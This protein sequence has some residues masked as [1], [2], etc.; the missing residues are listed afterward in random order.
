MFFLRFLFLQAFLQKLVRNLFAEGNDLFREK[1]FKLALVQ[2]VEGLNVA[3]YAASDEVAIPVDLL[4]KLHV[5]RA[6]CYF[7][8]VSSLGASWCTCVLYLISPSFD[9]LHISRF[10]LH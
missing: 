7:A 5:N 3:E 8:M 4:C 10:K 9:D 1:D 2:Y 6:A